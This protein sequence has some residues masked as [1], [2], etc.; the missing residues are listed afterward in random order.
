MQIKERRI[1]LADASMVYMKFR[2]KQLLLWVSRSVW[3]GFDVW[4]EAQP[5][6]NIVFDLNLAAGDLIEYFIQVMLT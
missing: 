2:S 5:I 3:C 4:F 1:F 6:V